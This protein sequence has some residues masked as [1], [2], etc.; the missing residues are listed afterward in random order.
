[1]VESDA[2]PTIGSRSSA[3]RALEAKYLPLAS[4]GHE[5]VVW[6]TAQG[7]RVRDVDGR[8]LIDFTSGVLVTNTGHAHPHVVAAIQEQVTHL[9][10][11]YDAPHPL[12]GEVA[13]RLVEHAGPPFEAVALLTTGAE[14]IDTA[15]KAAK[16]FTGRFEVISFAES[17]HGKTIGAM[18]MS[19]LPGTRGGLG[20]AVPG[21]IV[22]PYPTQYRCPVFRG[23]R[24]CDLTC[25]DVAVEV[26]RVNSVGAIAAV[27]VE[28]YLGAGGAYAPPLPFWKRLREF[29][30]RNGA[31][32]VFDEVQ[33]SFGRTGSFFAFQ[34]LGVIPDILVVAKGIASGIPMSAVLS[35]R[36]VLDA[37]PPG[38]LAS[39]YGGNPVSCAACLA[40]L[41]VMESEGLVERAARLGARAIERMGPWVGDIQ[42]VGDVRGMG[43]SLG[44]DLVRDATS[45]APDPSRAIDVVNAAD[46]EGV[47]VLPPAG[48]AGNVVRLAPPLVISDP[49]LELGLDRLERALRSTATA[50]MGT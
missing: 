40:T 18:S 50:T 9:L 26:A 19:G 37:L 10:N 36:E 4:P 49:D 31:L 25:F 42:G 24:C 23:E 13:R 41:D 34:Q 15:V 12:R 17:F 11:C 35:R 2:M 22:V 43:F 28:P 46:R 30:D 32:L 47:I 44:I 39:T 29:A 33:A 8:E 5:H 3:I 16:A 27:I 1:M 48:V 38:S 6:D 21:T 14:A 45:R 7:A 20:P